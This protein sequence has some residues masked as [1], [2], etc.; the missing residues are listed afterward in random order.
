MR[1]VVPGFLCGAVALAFV[2]IT[3]PA[4]GHAVLVESYPAAK[5]EVAGPDLEI[6]LKFN[7]R[8]DAPRSRLQLVL[9]DGSTRP[10]ILTSG[11]SPNLVT[12][13]ATGLRPGNYK[14]LWQVLASDGHIT[15]GAIPFVVK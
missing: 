9:A 1:K 11:G 10:L 3:A 6:R 13:S 14:L 7:V 12:S 8:I 2:L 5:S 4:W 15:R